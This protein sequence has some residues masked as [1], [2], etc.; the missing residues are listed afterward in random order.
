MDENN[1][2]NQE[3]EQDPSGFGG[4]F[5][6]MGNGIKN[7]MNKAGNAMKN[8]IK[9]GGKKALKV[10]GKGMKAIGK[11][12]SFMLKGVVTAIAPYALPIIAVVAVTSAGWF[13][14]FESKGETQDMQSED[15][16]E[17]NEVTLNNETGNIDLNAL[18][19]GNKLTKAFYTFYAEKS[20]YVTVTDKN[21]TVTQ[22]E[23][24]QYNSPE[25]INKF[26]ESEN[27]TVKDKYDREK[28]FYL[29]PNALY[30]LDE[31]LNKNN[32][33]YPEQFIKPVYHD[34]DTFA[35]K[36]L[37]D[38]NGTLIA[39]SAQYTFK[40]TQKQVQKA[41][42]SDGGK[43]KPVYIDNI[44]GEET[45]L[46]TASNGRINLA[47]MET[48]KSYV[49]DEVEDE[50]VGVW[51]YGFGSI[52]NYKEFEEERKA[53]GTFKTMNIWDVENE[54]MIYNVPLD[55]AERMCNSEPEKYEGFDANY[56]MDTPFE[57]ALP[58]STSYMID[59]VTSP[60][61]F[62]TNQIVSEWQDTGV[63]YA[64][65]ITKT[66]QVSVWREY[67]RQVQE[68]GYYV[69]IDAA[70]YQ[71][72]EPFYE[73]EETG[74][75]TY[76]TPKM[77]T[78]KV[79][80]KISQT[81]YIEGQGTKFEKIPR[82]QGEPDTSQVVGSKYFIDYMTNYRTY[83]PYDVMADLGVREFTSRTGA[84]QEELLKLLER[85]SFTGGTVGGADLDGFDLGSGASSQ[86]FLNAMQYYEYFEL[87]GTTYGVDPM[88]LVAIAA[89][90][91]SGNH[92]A[93]VSA[94]RC[95]VKGCGIMQ[96][97]K[98]G[99]V[100]TS[101][102]AHNFNTNTDD[103]IAVPNMDAVSEVSNNIRIGTMKL[104]QSIK[105]AEYNIPY[106]L[107]SYNF[108]SGGMNLILDRYASD[109]GKSREDVLKDLNDMGWIGYIMDFHKNPN[110]YLTTP[111]YDNADHLCD[112]PDCDDPGHNHYGDPGYI[113][114][115]LRYYVAQEGN[116]YPWLL[117][118]DGTKVSMDGSEFTMGTGV[119]GTNTDSWL[120]KLW[121][122]IVGHKS[123]IFPKLIPS[124][125]IQTSEFQNRLTEEQAWTAYKLMFALQEKKKLSEYDG[126]TEDDWKA[127]FYMWF[128]NPIGTKWKGQGGAVDSKGMFPDGMT[129]PLS[130][131]PLTISQTY[132]LPD[133]KGITIVAPNNTDVFAISSGKV[134]VVNDRETED[135]GKYIEITH[136]SGAKTVY[137]GLSSISVSKG[138]NI[139]NGQ[140]IGK[141][142]KSYK[143]SEVLYL[144]LN[145]QNKV[146]DPTWIISGTFNADDYDMTDSDREAIEKII[147]LAYTKLGA[148]Y[149]QA[150]GLRSGPNSFDCSGFTWW[151]YYT[152][153]GKNIGS[154][155]GEQD[156][157]LNNYRV[158]A[159]D[160]QPGDILMNN[161]LS[162]VVLYIGKVNGVDTVIQAANENL[163]VIKTQY[164]NLTSIYPK[165]YRPIA[166]K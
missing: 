158:N 2:E 150:Q 10:A 154:W 143:K 85:Q 107:Q 99:I 29:N 139:S 166:L 70:G 78:Y 66:K 65:T 48:V 141:T 92:D 84:S 142:G 79:K 19:T 46:P 31:Y 59:R 44:T 93:N 53:V 97:E 13:L 135:K 36:P 104:T 95:A 75:K 149:T 32:F 123:D 1:Q 37:T 24:L 127:K 64:K 14:I 15:Y 51:D 49:R 119:V 6:D 47:K 5:S 145:Y 108:G 4:F 101:V 23:P 58:S 45:F 87:W 94:S 126:F 28:M 114:H 125:G 74:Y 30:V 18:S 72:Y 39:K 147:Q 98:P 124:L 12:I 63:L 155:T 67:E 11:G 109:V 121:T 16:L 68:S 27:R 153:T 34:P 54:T 116:D 117:K 35:L 40:E 148:T 159:A 33:R 91:S 73:D 86:S 42:D 38:E 22:K 130:F 88:L 83:V 50:V 3:L 129:K 160:L 71:T 55:E 82:Y 112:M 146:A 96:I 9:K 128:T 120:K 115:I 20:I 131:S 152:V 25:F 77:E 26:G 161:D 43:V 62:I 122:K 156:Q 105:N 137:G 132:S 60:S 113:N 110:A 41:D 21:G 151:L 136:S 165:I 100:T 163:G 52:L 56:K 106:L 140:L 7:G 17:Y 162:H 164:S 118:D 134:T 138:D 103:T 144:E 89:Q 61:G 8:G 90:E 81:F 157:F 102:T 80:E 76:N 69:Y 57:D 111:W 133:N